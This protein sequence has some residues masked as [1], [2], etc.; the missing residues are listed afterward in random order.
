MNPTMS[1]LL[2]AVQSTDAGDVVAAERHLARAKELARSSAR[3]DRHV[4]EIAALVV[5]GR[6]DRARGL[7]SVHV[8]E[9]PD[10]ATL[11]T[12]LLGG[13]A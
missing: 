13:P 12:Q 1:A 4:V 9:F 6:R 10:D 2:L 5:S 8:T 3:S 7:A 11:L